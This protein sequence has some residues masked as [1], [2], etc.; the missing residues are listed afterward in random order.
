M[1]CSYVIKTDLYQLLSFVLE[2]RRSFSH[3]VKFWTA[4]LVVPREI[5]VG[6]GNVYDR[7]RG[8]LRTAFFYHPLVVCI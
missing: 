1:Q 8:S 5:F 4:D 7:K 6:S 3:W 2:N